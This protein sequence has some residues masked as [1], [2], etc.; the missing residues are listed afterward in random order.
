M[1]KAAL[2]RSI[3]DPDVIEIEDISVGRPGAGEMLVRTEAVGLNR[4][5]SIFRQGKYAINP[6]PPCWIG[7]EGVA[8]VE[9]LGEGVSGFSAGDRVCVLPTFR[10]GQYGLAAER[11]IM[12]AASMIRSLDGMDPVAAAALWVSYTTAYAM[13]E[14]AGLGAGDFVIISA[15]SSSVGT[16]AIQIARAVG[17]IPI[18]TTRRSDKAASLMEVG[19]E[20][21]I[22]TQ[23]ADLVA[24]VM[25]I[26]GGRGARVAFDAIVGPFMGTLADAMADEGVIVVYGDLSGEPTPYPA[27][28]ACGKGLRIHGFVAP[29][30][31]W[32]KAE[33]FERAR[34]FIE[35]GVAEGTLR[36]IIARTFP[37]DQIVEAHRYLE[38]NVQVGKVVLT[39]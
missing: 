10:P 17:A 15:A 12:P 14:F 6:V 35:A 28:P 20:H 5:E 24:E 13:V 30:H 31:I 18:A 38:S 23:E 9:A 26:T 11:A 34:K 32:G 3:G 22:A 21:V 8:I 39:I 27:W 16:A 7:G 19:A 1:T 36:P 2:F 4:G 29:R 25:R 37:L 33:R